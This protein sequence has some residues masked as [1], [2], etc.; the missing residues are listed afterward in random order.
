MDDDLGVTL[1]CFCLPL[2]LR[3]P[4]VCGVF[5]SFHSLLRKYLK[6][7]THNMFSSMLDSQVSFHLLVMNKAFQLL[8]NTT[9]TFTSYAFEVLS[10][11]ASYGKL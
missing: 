8:K 7:K 10:S 5:D 2:T 11:L 1:N 6:R 3:S 4:S 9:K